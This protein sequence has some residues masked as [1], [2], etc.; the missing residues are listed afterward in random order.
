M[1][2]DG[3]QEKRSGSDGAKAAAEGVKPKGKAK[4]KTSKSRTDALSQPK[5]GRPGSGKNGRPSSGKSDGEGGT[6]K[7]TS[8]KK[9]MVCLENCK[10][11]L[12]ARVTANAG[13]RSVEEDEPWNLHWIDTS[14]SI[15]RVMRMK[16]FQKINHFPGMAEISRKDFLAKNLTRMQKM[17]PE[18]YNFFPATFT[19]PNDANLLRDFVRSKKGKKKLTLIVKPSVGCQGKGIYLASSCDKINMTE[20]VVAQTYV[21]NPLLIDGLKFD[22]R[23]YV[24]VTSCAPLRV[25]IFKEGLARFATKPYVKPN[26][27]NIDNAFMHL[28]NYS[29]NKHSEDFVPAASASSTADGADGTGGTA[30]VVD[31]SQSS[32]RTI[33][34]VLNWLNE[35]GHDAEGCWE[36]I[37]TMLNK[38]LIAIQPKL[39]HAYR[40][41]FSGGDHDNNCFEILGFDVLLD[42]KLKPWLIEVNHSPSFNTDSHLDEVC[43][44]RLVADTLKLVGIKASSKKNYVK[45]LRKEFAA[46]NLNEKRPSARVDEL[47]SEHRHMSTIATLATQKAQKHNEEEGKRLAHE[48]KN[49][50]DYTRIYPPPALDV[51][52]ATGAEIIATESVAAGP[53]YARFFAGATMIFTG[54]FSHRDSTETT[55]DRIARLL[56]A[57]EAGEQEDEAPAKNSTVKEVDEL[58]RSVE[59]K[60]GLT[61][62]V[63]MEAQRP[64]LMDAACMVSGSTQS[65]PEWG[66][67][68]RGSSP[69]VAASAAANSGSATPSPSAAAAAVAT[70]AGSDGRGGPPIHRRHTEPTKRLQRPG[71]SAG[72]RRRVS[73]RKSLIDRAD[74][75]AQRVDRLARPKDAATA[76]AM[77]R[78]TE[79]TRSSLPKLG[80]PGHPA[81]GTA[82]VPISGLMPGTAAA[83]AGLDRAAAS[84]NSGASLTGA[85]KLWGHSAVTELRMRIRDVAVERGLD[86]GEQNFSREH[87]RGT[88]ES[89]MRGR[90]QQALGSG[91]GSTLGGVLGMTITS[92]KEY[93]GG[94][95]NGWRIPT[96]SAGGSG[97]AGS[98]GA[99][100]A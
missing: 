74:N 5:G 89:V 65:A 79:G 18:D 35:N 17:F 96:A 13:F 30:D 40:T 66:R 39:A 80:E 67:P 27:S 61:G 100:C 86:R 26:D 50:G 62:K 49:C 84:G 29:L 38:T 92:Y 70:A 72:A 36:R 99:S 83:V 88:L 76:T 16:K 14:V 68:R 21:R 75:L 3:E 95:P 59:P 85:E 10:Y 11:D 90:Q 2:D 71:G 53:P 81:N 37:G 31:E 91:R 23:I 94:A 55:S 15:E 52:D 20:P 33:A 63:K 78:L 98:S 77:Q 56:A 46:R 9:L 54:E 87:S 58:L 42:E 44:N 41:C 22:L 19:M 7:K 24:L 60:L 82:G 57:E 32:K 8:K 47:A 51:V 4:G 25:Y 6:K 45:Q 97:N 48:Q 43:K 73:S 69:V 93:N 1:P 12:I 64:K 34:W 28:T